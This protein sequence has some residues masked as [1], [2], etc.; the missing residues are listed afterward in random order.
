[1]SFPPQHVRRVTQASA[2]HSSVE[3]SGSEE[4]GLRRC[5]GASPFK[6]F[7][8]ELGLSLWNMRRCRGFWRGNLR[9]GHFA[10]K[11]YCIALR[12][13]ASRYVRVSV[14]VEWMRA[15]FGGWHVRVEI[16]DGLKGKRNNRRTRFYF[17]NNGER[18][19]QSFTLGRSGIPCIFILYGSIFVKRTN[20]SFFFFLNGFESIFLAFKYINVTKIYLYSDTHKSRRFKNTSLKEKRYILH[21]YYVFFFLYNI[22]N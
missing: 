15:V 17:G 21:K 12:V 18:T 8:D 2:P 10:G 13:R 3:K 4:A 1:M 11:L 16:C 14:D 20:T 9:L 5:S 22:N 6:R 19:C 7:T